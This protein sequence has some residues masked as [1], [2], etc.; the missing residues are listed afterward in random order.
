M[1]AGLEAGEQALQQLHLATL[2]DK[3]LCA[4]VDWGGVQRSRDEVRVVAVLAHL[5]QHVG[6]ARDGCALLPLLHLCH[7]LLQHKTRDPSGLIAIKKERD[8]N[9]SG[10]QMQPILVVQMTCSLLKYVAK[11][12]N[13]LLP[14]DTIPHIA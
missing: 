10:S 1:A 6:Q 8:M 4:R 12:L 5:H 13:T 7:H 9:L 14:L 2:L 3:L 11:A